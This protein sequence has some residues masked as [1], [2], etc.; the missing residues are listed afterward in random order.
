MKRRLLI[1]GIVLLGTIP[2]VAVVRSTLT[3]AAPTTL[4]PL[5]ATV[6]GS[7]ATESGGPVTAPPSVPTPET[8][9]EQ[10]RILYESVDGL[11]QVGEFERARRLLD[12]DQQ[13]YGGDSKSWFELAQGYRLLADCLEHS[14]M[15]F[16]G[17]AE[18]FLR[19]HE[20][21]ALHHR[22]RA[23]CFEPRD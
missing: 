6:V 18:A 8:R 3:R 12:D 14:D 16:R 1:A 7:L 2:C 4:A 22:L 9:L 23:A 15:R 10:R 13:R 17:T 19:T 11:L 20:A 21:P 5:E